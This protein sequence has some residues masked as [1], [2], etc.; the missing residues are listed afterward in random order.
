MVLNH[1][2]PTWKMTLSTSLGSERS[3]SPTARPSSTMTPSSNLV[4]LPPPVL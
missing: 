2:I 1:Q 4:T 3:R